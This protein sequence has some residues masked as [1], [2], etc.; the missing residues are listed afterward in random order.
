M[1]RSRPWRISRAAWTGWLLGVLLQLGAF[2][3]LAIDA[4]VRA[5]LELQGDA[6]IGQQVILKIDLMSNGLSFSSQRIY[7]PDVPGA[8]VLEDTVSTV[9]LSEQI[10]G[11]TWQVVSYHYPLFAQRPGRIELEPVNVA[12]AVSAGFGREAEQFEL[13]TEPLAFE[14]RTPPGVIDPALL[15]TTTDFSLKVT[16]TPEP[17]ELKVGDALTRT[18]TRTADAV[19]GMAFA[20]LPL[21]NIEGVAAYPKTPEVDDRSNR[22]EL[23]G[24][25]VESVSYVLQRPGRVTIPGVVLQWWDPVAERLNTEKIPSLDLDVAVNP[26]LVLHTDLLQRITRLVSDHPWVLPAGILAVAAI[27][28]AM[29]RWLPSA[30]RRLQH[31]RRSRRLSETARFTALLQACR[32]NDPARV[33]NAYQAWLAGEGSPAPDVRHA[34]ALANELE[35]LQT[36]LVRRDPD[37]HAGALL[38]EVQAARNMARRNFRQAGSRA[39]PALNP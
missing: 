18:V 30:I 17:A 15:V 31:W 20:P 34:Q 32:S 25:R 29:F 21:T 33:Y 36:A 4:Q 38:R 24:T 23:T 11:E 37:W 35:R 14:V 22:G 12:F 28:W 10:D 16:V 8:L 19:S 3:A 6:W 1:S 13:Q 26:D 27:A 2:P 7:L 39:L 9:K 5:A